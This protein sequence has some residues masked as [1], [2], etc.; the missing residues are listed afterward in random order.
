[1]LYKSDMYHAFLSTIL[2]NKESERRGN[3]AAG[4]SYRRLVMFPSILHWTVV[5]GYIIIECK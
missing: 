3:M 1:M 2:L 5:S 4:E